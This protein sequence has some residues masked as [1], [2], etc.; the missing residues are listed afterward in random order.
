MY[1]GMMSEM[2]KAAPEIK[3]FY[4]KTNDAGAGI[5]WTDWLYS[6]PNGPDHCKNQSAGERVE[7]LM[8]AFKEG[9]SRAGRKITIYLSAGDSNFSDEEKE[10]IAK[11]LPEDCY[12]EGYHSSGISYAGSFMS[13]SY[14]VTGII[15]PLSLINRTKSVKQAK[16]IFIS[17]GAA[18]DRGYERLD[19][20]SF[21]IDVLEKQIQN[22]VA[23]GQI[24]ALQELKSFSEDWAG[25]NSADR[26]FNAF[27]VLDEALTYKNVV[28]PRISALYWGVSTRH[29]TRPLVIAPLRLT[30]KEEAYFLPFVF[31]VSIGEA[32]SDYTDIHGTHH[33]I[34][35]SS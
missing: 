20:F 34:T 16:T 18:Y 25:K 6:G 3:T 21:L 28:I 22:Q 2:L 35:R 10:D 8:N 19:A 31:N 24:P 14:P 12:F 30:E 1:A 27:I 23:D 9:A 33:V 7:M 17:L 11:H 5:C 29:I 13:E 32:R 15:N 26:L 4:F